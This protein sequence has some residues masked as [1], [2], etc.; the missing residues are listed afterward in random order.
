MI[1]TTYTIIAN[2][3]F[4]EEETETFEVDAVAITL[5]SE[6]GGIMIGGSS[7]K[8]EGPPLDDASH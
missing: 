5:M 7:G 1:L 8:L 2:T 4:T 3:P 6:L